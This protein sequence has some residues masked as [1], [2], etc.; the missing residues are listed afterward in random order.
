MENTTEKD[1]RL[2]RAKSTQVLSPPESENSEEDDSLR[3]EEN[4]ENLV[5][6]EGDIGGKKNSGRFCEKCDK[7]IPNWVLKDMEFSKE[8]IT[9]I[10]AIYR[11]GTLWIHLGWKFCPQHLSIFADHMC[12]VGVTEKERVQ[13]LRAMYE[14]RDPQA[15]A[16]LVI[17]NLDWFEPEEKL[18]LYGNKPGLTLALKRFAEEEGEENPG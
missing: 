15:L 1:L 6:R 14:S 4:N 10:E 12:L 11:S 3:A 9:M 5:K 8:R 2:K 16:R 7:R 13:R 17:K 18:W